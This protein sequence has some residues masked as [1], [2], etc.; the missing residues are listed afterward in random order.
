MCFYMTAFI[1]KVVTL[2]FFV[3]PEQDQRKRGVNLTMQPLHKN[4]E[5]D[6]INVYSLRKISDVHSKRVQIISFHTH[7]SRYFNQ[8]G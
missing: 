8:N 7:H 6:V 3:L 1:F 4:F 5:Q 2:M